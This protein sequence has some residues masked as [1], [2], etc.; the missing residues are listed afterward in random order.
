MQEEVIGLRST[1]TCLLLLTLVGCKG[2]DDA[3]PRTPEAELSRARE[4]LDP[5]DFGPRFQEGIAALRALP[6]AEGVAKDVAMDAFL[7]QAEALTDLFLAARATGEPL[8][9]ETLEAVTDWELEG[10]LD[11]PRNLQILAQEI[12]EIFDLVHRELG[13]DDP[14]AVRAALMSGL[15]RDVQAVVFVKKDRLLKTLVE[16]ETALDGRYAHRAAMVRLGE[17]LRPGPRNWRGH[18]LTTLGFPCPRGAAGLMAVLCLPD[19]D[20]EIMGQCLM[21]GVVHDTG[22]RGAA[23]RI[24]QARCGELDAVGGDPRAGIRGWYGAQLAVIQASDAPL[25]VWVRAFRLEAWTAGLD[26]ALAPAFAL[27]QPD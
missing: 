12:Q 2:G 22:R 11:R 20:A 14:R 7:L 13:D 6:K 18:V 17:L 25:A 16:L 15:L 8:L 4:L 26:A 3:P 1:T 27:T 24:L 5:Y 9:A 10:G 19:P 23:G 21:E